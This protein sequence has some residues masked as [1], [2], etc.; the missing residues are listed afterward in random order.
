MD[1]LSSLRI[2]LGSVD[3]FDT[4]DMLSSG[5][6]LSVCFILSGCWFSFVVV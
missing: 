4:W 5:F 3:V 6:I 2:L 1:F